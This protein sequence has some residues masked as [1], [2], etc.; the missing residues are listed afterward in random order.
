LA[1]KQKTVDKVKNGDFILL[2]YTERV[3]DTDQIIYTTRKD[4]AEKY[5]IVES[6]RIYEPELIIVGEGWLLEPFDKALSGK[7]VGK[8]YKIEVPPEKAFGKIDPKK[9]ETFSFRELRRKNIR[10]EVGKEIEI[11][12]RIGI[13]RLIG[14]GRVIVDFNHPLAGKTLEF[15]F[16]IL[17]KITDDKEKIKYMV[18][19]RIK[20]INLKDINVRISPKKKEVQITLPERYISDPNAAIMKKGISMD[21][22]KYFKDISSVVFI[23]RFSRESS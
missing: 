5:G 21:I 12:G 13:V 20:G 3:V 6:N 2:D 17:K 19:K 15:T 7:V 14:S 10:P 18:K 23:D 4:I 11:G 8:E 22:F 9:I 16:K 1:T